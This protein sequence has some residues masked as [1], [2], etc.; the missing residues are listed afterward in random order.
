[1]Y[2]SAGGY[3]PGPRATYPG[4]NP[5]VGLPEAGNEDIK[6]SGLRYIQ[7]ANQTRRD[8]SAAENRTKLR[9]EQSYLLGAL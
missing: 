8:A 7:F 5:E 6:Y 9:I 3:G 2:V 4:L 1:M